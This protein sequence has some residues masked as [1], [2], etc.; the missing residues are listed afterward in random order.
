MVF[1]RLLRQLSSIPGGVPVMLFPG[2]IKTEI[3]GPSRADGPLQ[4]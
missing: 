2:E 3:G 4:G 1:H